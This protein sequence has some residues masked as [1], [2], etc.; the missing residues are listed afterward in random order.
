MTASPDRPAD[1]APL[2]RLAWLIVALLVPVA[3]LGW[4]FV[5]PRE[6]TDAQRDVARVALLWFALAFTLFSAM[7]TKFH[8]YI[9]PA[10]PGAAVMVGLLVDRMLPKASSDAP[11]RLD[12]WLS[13]ALGVL[14]LVLGVARH[15]DPLPLQ[16]GAAGIALMAVA[17]FAG[18]GLAEAVLTITGVSLLAW[19]HLRNLRHSC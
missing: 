4:R 12:L 11:P 3:L 1:G 8:H 14:L 16:V 13:R 5:V 7:I 9:F 6:A 15:G 18:H 19:A 17:L 10:L 2:P